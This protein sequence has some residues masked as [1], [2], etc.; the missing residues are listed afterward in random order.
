MSIPNINSPTELLS[1][2]ASVLKGVP[3]AGVTDLDSL[4]VTV[5]ALQEIVEVMAGQRGEIE[6]QYIRVRDLLYCHDRII[7]ILNSLDAR[8]TA[9]EP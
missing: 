9:L 3:D 4:A 7:S 5:R 6:E 8:I 2:V 1:P